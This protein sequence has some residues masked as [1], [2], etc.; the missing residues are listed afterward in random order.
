MCAHA[1]MCMAQRACGD[2]EQLTGIGSLLGIK[3]AFPEALFKGL[4]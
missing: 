4:Y 1:D 2:R 3:L